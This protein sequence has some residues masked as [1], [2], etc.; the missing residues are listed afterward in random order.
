MS[1]RIFELFLNSEPLAVDRRGILYCL[2]GT[3]R[4]APAGMTWVTA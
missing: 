2:V 1:D 3:G 4:R